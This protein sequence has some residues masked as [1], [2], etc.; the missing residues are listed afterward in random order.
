MLEEVEGVLNRDNIQDHRPAK[1]TS[2]CA[3]LSN[4]RARVACTRVDR[5][6]CKAEL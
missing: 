5:M 3:L 1:S 6:R 2:R 4:F